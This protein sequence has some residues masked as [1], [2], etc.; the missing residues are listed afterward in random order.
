M[1]KVHRTLNK[2]ANNIYRFIESIET[3]STETRTL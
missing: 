3:F 2:C 1:A